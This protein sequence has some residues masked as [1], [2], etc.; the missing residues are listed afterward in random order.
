MPPRATRQASLPPAN[1]VGLRKSQRV[2]LSSL[3]HSYPSPSR[4]FDPFDAFALGPLSLA[5]DIQ[6]QIGRMLTQVGPRGPLAE[7]PMPGL[8]P[9]PTVHRR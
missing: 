4:F 2:H 1:S 9:F 5:R 7:K 3:V 8:S 6:E